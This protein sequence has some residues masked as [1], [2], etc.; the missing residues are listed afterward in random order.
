VTRRIVG[1]FVRFFRA[2]IPVGSPNTF[3]WKN[4]I[5]HTVIRFPYPWFNFLSSIAFFAASL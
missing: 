4:S 5:P 3:V 1:V 2:P